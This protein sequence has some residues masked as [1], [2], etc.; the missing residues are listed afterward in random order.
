M[1]CVIEPEVRLDERDCDEYQHDQPN[2][3]KTA[4]LRKVT[5]PDAQLVIGLHCQIVGAMKRED[6]SS[7]EPHENR[8]PV[9]NPWFRARH[10][11][12]PECDEEVAVPVQRYATDQ[13]A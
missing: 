9:K 8:V 11:V 7:Y 4:Q 12:C 6:R 2:H 5:R 10:E 3:G 13:I 1:G